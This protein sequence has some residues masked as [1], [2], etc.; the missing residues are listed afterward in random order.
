M[1][2]VYNTGT[3]GIIYVAKI[4]EQRDKISRQDAIRL[5]IETKEEML[6]AAAAGDVLLADDILMDNLGLEPDYVF[7][8][9]G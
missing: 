2:P 4:I 5:V 8:L 1:T 7:D 3:P 6:E 9:M